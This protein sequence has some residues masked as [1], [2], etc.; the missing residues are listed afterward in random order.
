MMRAAGRAGQ[1]NSARMQLWWILSTCGP[2]LWLGQ[3]QCLWIHSRSCGFFVWYGWRLDR[4]T[5]R[6]R[7]R[8]II[9][10]LCTP[11]CNGESKLVVL[12]VDG[13]IIRITRP[14]NAN[15]SY[16][17]GRAGKNCDSL[18]T[19]FIVD[20]FGNVRHIVTG[21]S[22]KLRHIFFNNGKTFLFYWIE[23]NLLNFLL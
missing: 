4:V 1:R 23:I 20:K 16:Y 12:Y 7:L 9:I 22:G 19:Q 8:C 21:L 15:D 6:R 2:H 5:R 13:S 14:D 11:Q 3:K 18:N 10:R 17:C